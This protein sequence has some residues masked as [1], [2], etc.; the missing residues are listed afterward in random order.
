[1]G[2]KRPRGAITNDPDPL[3]PFPAPVGDA[4]PVRVALR[5]EV[6]EKLVAHEQAVGYAVAIRDAYQAGLV[7]GLGFDLS[8]VRALDVDAGELVVDAE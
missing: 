4:E 7:D 6:V 5:P 3:M 2:Q 8:R 1:M